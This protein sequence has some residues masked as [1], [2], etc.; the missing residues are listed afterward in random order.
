MHPIATACKL[1]CIG[2]EICEIRVDYSTLIKL[3]HA[4]GCNQEG[5]GHSMAVE[6]E[7]Y[8][9]RSRATRKGSRK[10]SLA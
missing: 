8:L 3:R 5:V 1:K 10:L 6:A 9:L 4:R 7:Q 2:Q